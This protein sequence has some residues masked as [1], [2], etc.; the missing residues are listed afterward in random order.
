MGEIYSKAGTTKLMVPAGVYRCGRPARSIWCEME[1][2]P[3]LDGAGG[4]G[5]A[6]SPPVSELEWGSRKGWGDGNH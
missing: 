2:R 1:Q 6:E 4:G 5:G 3:A